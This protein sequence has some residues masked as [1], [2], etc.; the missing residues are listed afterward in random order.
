MHFNVGVVHIG[1]GLHDLVEVF[2]LR[3]AVGFFNSVEDRAL[4]S[5]HR[6]NVET[7]HE[8]DI[9]H[10]KHVRGIDH[11]DGQRC[12]YPAQRQ[13]LI[14]LRGLVGNQL[15]DRGVNFE[16]GKI[17]RRHPV[18]PGKEIGH[19]LVGEEV[20]LHQC[21]AQ[22][23]VALLL[24]LGRLLQLLWGNDLLF[25]EKVAQS[26]GHASISYLLPLKATTGLLSRLAGMCPVGSE[27][28]QIRRDTNC[29][30]D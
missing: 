7:G 25:Y 30:L 26:L 18:L 17:D 10:G 5:H 1:Y 27:V 24:Y 15:D 3:A 28:T 8:L 14:T 11:G 20:E 19:V 2:F 9:V 12:T 4:G 13:N 29:H 23:T 6:F 16:I 21:A 22:A